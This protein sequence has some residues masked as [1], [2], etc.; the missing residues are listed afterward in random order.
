[1]GGNYPL[2]KISPI[3]INVRNPSL[4]LPLQRNGGYLFFSTFTGVRIPSSFVEGEMLNQRT[5]ATKRNFLHGPCMGP[6]S[7]LRNL[8]HKVFIL[9]A[10][11]EPSSAV[12]SKNDLC[13]SWIVGN[14]FLSSPIFTFP[15]TKK[16][17][18]WVSDLGLRWVCS[19]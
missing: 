15:K 6:G 10:V 3:Q 14:I 13:T 2:K 16:M 19:M 4:E 5:V 7:D 1:M 11:F 18:V 8:F 17:L 12:G 9:I